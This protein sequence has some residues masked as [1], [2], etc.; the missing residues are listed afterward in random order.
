MN[1]TNIMKV[2]FGFAYINEETNER[3]YYIGME[4]APSDLA[5]VLK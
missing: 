3:Y 1:H 2:Y 5:K 4:C